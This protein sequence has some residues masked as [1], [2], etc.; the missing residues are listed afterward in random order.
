MC[1]RPSGLPGCGGLCWSREGAGGRW[2]VGREA[3]EWSPGAVGGCGNCSALSVLPAAGGR[4]AGGG[5]QG[6][7]GTGGMIAGT[8]G[9][10][11]PRGE[12]SEGFP[13]VELRYR[14]LLPFGKGRSEALSVSELRSQRR[15]QVYSAWNSVGSG[16]L[17]GKGG[18]L[19]L[20]QP[21]AQ[22]LAVVPSVVLLPVGVSRALSRW[23][24]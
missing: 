1:V 16:G 9:K 4:G 8:W 12:R 7:A 5:W 19:D 15:A 17:C 20:R 10:G 2:S 13:A 18:A 22:L 21:S 3:A 11:L 23:V 14:L 6:A 24:L